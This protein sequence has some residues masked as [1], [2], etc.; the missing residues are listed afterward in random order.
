METPDESLVSPSSQ[1]SDVTLNKVL[2]TYDAQ[3]GYWFV[4]GGGSWKNNNWS[5]D[6]PTFL[7]PSVGDSKNVGGMDAIGVT[8]YNTS[9]DY[10]ASVISSLG[11]WHD[12]EGN[13]VESNSPSEGNGKYGVAFE[14]QDKA[15]VTSVNYVTGYYTYKYLGQ[16]FSAVVTYN[17]NFTNWNG[18]ARTFYAHTWSSTNISSISLNGSNSGFGASVTFSSSSNNFKI[19]NDADT[20]F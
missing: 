4:A 17:S 16:G 12:G 15:I 10:N 9:G 1:G 14:F 3:T 13:S 2:I 18:K 20:S 5:A 11:Y 7:I 6:V 19:Y 8:Y